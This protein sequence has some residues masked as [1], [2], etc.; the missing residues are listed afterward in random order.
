MAPEQSRQVRCIDS[1]R[2]SAAEQAEILQ[3]LAEREAHGD[4]S[5]RRREPRLPFEHRIEVAICAA[6]GPQT[7]YLVQGRNLTSRGI[8][9]LHGTFMYSHTVC[10]VAMPA[11]DGRTIVT[12]GQVVRCQLVRRHIHDIGVRFDKRIALA[13]YV[14][15]LAAPDEEPQQTS[16]AAAGGPLFSELWTDARL[17]PMVRTFVPRLR[18]Q[19]LEAG[20]LVTKDQCGLVLQKLCLEIRGSAGGYGYPRIATLAG[21]LLELILAGQDIAWQK[22]IMAEMIELG[23]SVAQAIDEIGDGTDAR[24]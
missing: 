12:R 2:L 4:R 8:G 5:E 20:R 14:G 24:A 16:D 10:S 22:Q 9:F 17:R 7:H 21:Q 15:G 19:I 18:E 23:R 6:Y 11:L 13:D 3:S 1:L